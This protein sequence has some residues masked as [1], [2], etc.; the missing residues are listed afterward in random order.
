MRNKDLVVRYLRINELA[1]ALILFSLWI[2]SRSLRNSDLGPTVRGTGVS[3]F[4]YARGRLF[5]LLKVNECYRDFAITNH[6]AERERCIISLMEEQVSHMSRTTVRALLALLMGFQ[7]VLWAS[8]QGPPS[9]QTPT[10]AAQVAK[11]AMGSEIEVR[12]FNKEK[13]RGRL[14]EVS[15]T[16]FILLIPSGTAS[17]KRNLAFDDVK[18]VRVVR[19]RLV[20][21]RRPRGPAFPLM[22]AG[23]VVAVILL[24]AVR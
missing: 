9:Q 15:G 13:L 7:G 22:V 24:I 17:I 6:P 11:I 3:L 14:G 8:P 21:T 2:R 10:I 23:V 18:S 1:V 4:D 19:T 5:R 16:G 20:R 12:L